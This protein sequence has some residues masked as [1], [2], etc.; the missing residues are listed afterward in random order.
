MQKKSSERGQATFEIAICS[1]ALMLV[2]V[3][4]LSVGG[5]GI[6][7]IK[8]LL[9][10]R[11][12]AEALAVQSHS[13][14]DNLHDRADW[15]PT[16]INDPSWGDPVRVPFLAHDREARTAV[17]ISTDYLTDKSVS[18]SREGSGNPPGHRSRYHFLSLEEVPS[19]EYRDVMFSGSSADLAELRSS[20]DKLPPEA[21]REQLY[22]FRTLE[23]P[24][25]FK[26]RL[27]PWLDL[28]GVDIR[29]WESSQISYPAL[30]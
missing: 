19:L 22:L 27:S 6:T 7:S 30:R 17:T 21:S 10:N 8:S 18:Y 26:E 5:I 3:A 2:T 29:R 24:A 9:L 28:R 1:I 23:D 16:E 11:T 13:G 15:R 4:L 14:A 20:A 12:Q 25:E